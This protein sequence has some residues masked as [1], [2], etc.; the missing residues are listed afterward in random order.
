MRSFENTKEIKKLIGRLTVLSRFVPKLAEKT[1][2]IVQLLR[3]AAKFQWTP[4]CEKIFLHL[5]EFFA[6]LPVIQKSND[7]RPIIVYLAVSE[8]AVS[9]TL[10]QEI[11]KEKRSVYFIS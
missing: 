9:A 1:R 2:L 4:K 10:V 7:Q 8:E 6:A 11:E 5:K 3:K